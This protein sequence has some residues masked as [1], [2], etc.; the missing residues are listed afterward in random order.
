MQI[1]KKAHFLAG[2]AIAGLCVAYGARPRDALFIAAFVG[3]MKE[4][5][6]RAGYGTPDKWDFVVTTI[7]GLTVLPLEFI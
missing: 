6:D 3:A 7:G 5:F 1:D 2:A 4:V